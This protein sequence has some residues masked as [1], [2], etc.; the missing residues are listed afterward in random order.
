VWLILRTC[1]ET[2]KSGRA[3]AKL[4]EAEDAVAELTTKL[5][6]VQREKADLEMRLVQFTQ[7]LAER[8]ELIAQLRAGKEVGRVVRSGART[9]S[10][11]PFRVNY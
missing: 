1:P 2:L 4:K 8:D 7:T 11:S 3:Q 10:T 5:A 9:C 6:A